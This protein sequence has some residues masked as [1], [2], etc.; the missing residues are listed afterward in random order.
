MWTDERVATLRK[1]VAAQNSAGTIGRMMGCTRNSIIG[2]VARL[3]LS[4]A[5]STKR[6][7]YGEVSGYVR[8]ARPRRT[9][10]PQLPRSGIQH[11]P[12]EPLPP[13]HVDDVPRV[14]F[15]ELEP[16]HC[17]FPV[18]DP[19]QPGFGFCGG[20]KVEGLPYCLGHVQRAYV[21]AQPRRSG[22]P[23]PSYT[24]TVIRKLHPFVSDDERESVLETA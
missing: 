2:K 22:N 18:G 12:R 7:K 5:G 9:P 3:G 10:K 15:A 14:S 19:Q 1:L 23:S 24:Q 4:F 8:V 6:L 16:H 13:I 11:P 21:P 20:E 17:R